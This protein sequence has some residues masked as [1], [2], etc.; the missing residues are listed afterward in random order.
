MHRLCNRPDLAEDL[1]QQ[2]FLKAWRS[3]GR[4]RAPG[5]FHVWL[6]RI[7]VSIWV[8]ELRRREVNLSRWEAAAEVEAPRRHPGERVDLDR[9]LAQLPA[10]MRLCVVLAYSDGL[11]H[12]EICDATGMPLGTVKSHISRGAERLRLLLSDYGE[13][14]RGLRD[15]G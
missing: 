14:H 10:P 1:A 15:A 5:A 2:V 11:S 9:A 12:Q 6:S 7:M 3:I 13:G 4:L 8:E